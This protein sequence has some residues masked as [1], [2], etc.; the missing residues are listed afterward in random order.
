MKTT[1]INLLLIAGTA[2]M[3]V[4]Q[5]TEGPAQK[6][7]R[8][9]DGKVDFGGKG[10]W[11]PIWVLDWADPKYVDKAVEVPFTTW[12]LATFKERRANL[13]KDDPEGYCLP[14]GMPRYTGTP[15]P[16]QIIELPDRSIAG[17]RG[18]PPKSD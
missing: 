9:A 13:S 2:A 3:C 14:P 11:A 8:L 10:V 18:S 17:R 5:A 1:V 16:F 4:A 15:Y 7:P 12:G 6:T